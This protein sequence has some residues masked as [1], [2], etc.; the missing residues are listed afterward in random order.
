MTRDGMTAR[1]RDDLAALVR[2]RERVAKTATKQRAAELM[3]DVEQQLAA[4]YERDDKRW[5]EVNVVAKEAVAAADAEIAKRCRE[6][7]IPEEFRPGLTLGWYGRGQ[8]ATAA[9]RTELRRVA[10]TRIAAMEQAARAEIERRSVEVQTV[11][12]AGGLESGAAQAFLE[13]MPMPDQL[14]PALVVDELEA[15]VPISAG[16]GRGGDFD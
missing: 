8:N 5:S 15:V 9:R 13:S 1:E 4:V 2:R 10:A 11:L 6:L 12:L 14:M 3:A 16:R 7:G